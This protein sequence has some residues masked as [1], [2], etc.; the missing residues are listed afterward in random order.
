M[1]HYSNSSLGGALK[2]PGKNRLLAS[3][4]AKQIWTVGVSAYRAKAAIQRQVLPNS[5]CK[6]DEAA[7]A[8]AAGGCV[9]CTL[10][11]AA[12]SAALLELRV[13]LPWSHKA[14]DDAW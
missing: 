6:V 3:T 2:S 10:E 12:H 11:M 5:E 1:V 4:R 8:R 13:G 9:S 7:R 14:T